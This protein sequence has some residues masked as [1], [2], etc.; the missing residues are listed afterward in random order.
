ME[1]SSSRR[2]ALAVPI[3]IVATFALL[4]FAYP[5]YWDGAGPTP[6]FIYF[7]DL[8]SIAEYHANEWQYD[9][10]FL[11]PY[12]VVSLLIVAVTFVL[13]PK[14]A[15]RIDSGRITVFIL[16]FGLLSAVTGVSDAIVKTARLNDCVF[17]SFA[18]DSIVAFLLVAVPVA[19]LSA[20]FAER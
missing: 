15:K 13:A 2:F 4:R 7:G 8:P 17:L 12:F 5:I 14:L 16:A 20:L 11:L 6:S 9:A 19:L 10:R 3:Q 1:L 18:S